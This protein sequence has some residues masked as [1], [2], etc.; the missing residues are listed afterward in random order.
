MTKHASI[1]WERIRDG[2]AES[3]GVHRTD[4]GWIG[5]GGTW[6]YFVW[7]QARVRHEP[8]YYAG[9]RVGADGYVERYGGI[10]DGPR[11]SWVDSRCSWL[12][13][14]DDLRGA[15]QACVDDLSKRLESDKVAP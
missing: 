1:K 15:K 12:S 9:A 13:D 3:R 8:P 14:K 2:E 4:G 5:H 11:P 6:L 10:D 7:V